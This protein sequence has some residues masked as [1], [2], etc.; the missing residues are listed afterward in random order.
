MWPVWAM[1]L[2][3]TR[4]PAGLPG[5]SQGLP[6]SLGRHC[7]SPSTQGSGLLGDKGSHLNLLRVSVQVERRG[8]MSAD[9]AAA[10]DLGKFRRSPDDITRHEG[11]QPSHKAPATN[12][13]VRGAVTDVA[14]LVGEDLAIERPDAR[15]NSGLVAEELDA[16]CAEHREHRATRHL[17]GA[18]KRSGQR[19]RDEDGGFDERA[20]QRRGR[21][22]LEGKTEHVEDIAEQPAVV[23][24]LE[25]EV[26][27]LDGDVLAAVEAIGLAEADPEALRLV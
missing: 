12:C 5:Q 2:K 26:G 1:Q 22:D 16:P 20:H 25:F 18:N 11:I 13:A 10:K 14:D 4:T 17:G 23:V 19:S 7:S 27:A 3:T 9:L 8:D 24:L 15:C 21:H 6:A